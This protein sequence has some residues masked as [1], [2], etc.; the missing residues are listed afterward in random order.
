MKEIVIILKKNCNGTICSRGA[1]Y[2]NG[3]GY[4][5][6]IKGTF[7]LIAL[8]FLLLAVITLVLDITRS[9]ADSKLVMTALGQDWFTYSKSTLNFSQAIVQRYVH[10]ALWDPVIQT[11]LLGPSWLVF[12]VLALIFG[13]FGRKKRRKW[14]DHYGA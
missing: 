10:A 14:Q 3:F 11:I 4:L 6:M 1:K 2:N 5:L 7:K 9:I 13:F 12:G 8:L